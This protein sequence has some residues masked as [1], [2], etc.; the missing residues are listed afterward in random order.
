MPPDDLSKV[1]PIG[2]KNF[3]EIPTT[4]SHEGT[5]PSDNSL[6]SSDFLHKVDTSEV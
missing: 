1:R 4:I 5:S 3:F 6:L 2:L